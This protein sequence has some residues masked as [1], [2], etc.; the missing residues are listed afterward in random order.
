MFRHISWLVVFL[1]VVLTVPLAA[2]EKRIEVGIQGGWTF[3]DGVDR[4]SDPPVITGDGLVFHRIDPE[5]SFKWSITGGFLITDHYEV[6]FQYGQQN[7]TLV[8]SGDT[9][10]DVGDLRISSYH[11]YFSYN[12]FDGDARIRPYVLAGLGTTSYGDVDYTRLDGQTGTIIGLSRFSS[13]WGAGVKFNPSPAIGVRAGVQ[14]TPTYVK[15]DSAGYWC[16]QWWGCYETGSTQ[17]SN[18]WDLFGGVIIR[19]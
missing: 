1:C 14:F 16:D 18:Q 6:G 13:T 15:M 10:R 12:F 9:K 2:Q 17:Y 8:A 11:G 4:G 3:S 19:F 7:T 5:D